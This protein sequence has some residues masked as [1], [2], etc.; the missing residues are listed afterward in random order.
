[1][2]VNRRGK[3]GHYGRRLLAFQWFLQKSLRPLEPN[4]HVISDDICEHLIAAV[5]CSSPS[6][7][8]LVNTR[9]NAHQPRRRLMSTTLPS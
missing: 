3:G 2:N 7:P 6:L 5:L 9:C 1:M 4:F 8:C